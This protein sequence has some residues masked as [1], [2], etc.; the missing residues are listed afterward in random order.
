MAI[1]LHDLH[2]LNDHLLE[3]FQDDLKEVLSAGNYTLGQQVQRFEEQ[4]ARYISTKHCVGLSSGVDGIVL[5]LNAI[6]VGP[7]DE[8]LCPVFAPAPL[9]MAICRLGATP[10][11]VDC[12]PDSLNM[13]PDQAIASMNSSRTKAMIVIHMF[14]LAA[15]IDRIMTIARTYSVQ[16]IEVT[17]MATGARY[18]GR[19]LGT[20]GNFASFGFAPLDALGSIGSA[21]AL[22][23]N[24]DNYVEQFRRLRDSGRFNS[25]V[26][27]VVGYDSAMSAIQA[28]FLLRKLAELDDNNLDRIANAKL[29]NQLLEGAPVQTPPLREDMSHIYSTYVIQAPE[30]NALL[31]HLKEKGIETA[32]P[33]PSALHLEPCF[34]YLEYKEGAFPVAEDLALRS[35]ALPCGPGMKKNQIKEIC[36]AIQAYYAVPA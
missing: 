27:D 23:T 13:D 5:C 10:V 15:E 35:L 9:A 21:G 14:G 29:Y 24:D 33:I 34:R 32:S 16:V 6:G 3:D 30:R 1:S 17:T 25:P 31:E 7:G 26:H 11:F 36:S 22:T 19:R 18:H 28:A 2:A 8:V 4:F 20:F 12:R